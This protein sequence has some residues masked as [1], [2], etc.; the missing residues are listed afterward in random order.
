MSDIRRDI[1]SK[2]TA[3][4]H[5]SL[6]A[7]AYAGCATAVAHIEARSRQATVA[8]YGAIV[9]GI[10]DI[11]NELVNHP[12][13]TA[14]KLAVAGITGAALGAAAAA[15]SPIIANGAIFLGAAATG[16]ALW[17]S[18]KKL[19]RDKQ[20]REAM[21]AVYKLGDLKTMTSS[22]QAAADIIGP[23]AFNYGL[24]LLGM[25]AG[26]V[27]PGTCANLRHT[28][29]ANKLK[30]FLP[31]PEIT[32]F[33]AV[34]MRLADGSSL[35]VHGQQAVFRIGG[36]EYA[37]NVSGRHG[38]G[39]GL[40]GSYLGRQVLRANHG[41]DSL[42]IDINPEIGTTKVK[43]RFPMEYK[44]SDL[45]DKKPSAFSVICDECR[46]FRRS[47]HGDNEDSLPPF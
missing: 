11:P 4:C 33:R 38:I 12:W 31:M 30:P 22:M 43:G 7:D 26:V 14:G 42:E 44:H 39:V 27:G 10:R 18:Y 16:T 32:P 21:S 24:A 28:Y 5:K 6:F 36:K 35:H 41:R 3:D 20:L 13:E 15:E 17:G 46:S 1:S 25:R 8:T 23:E 40:R 2:S 37:I 47:M 29:Y 34:E 19:E 9:G 45:V